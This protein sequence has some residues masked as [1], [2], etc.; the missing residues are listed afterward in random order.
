MSYSSDLNDKDWAI[1][2]RLLSSLLEYSGS[3]RRSS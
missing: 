3:G 2:E 1:I